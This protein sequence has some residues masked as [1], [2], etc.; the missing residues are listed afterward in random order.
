MEESIREAE[1]KI[2]RRRTHSGDQITG[3]QN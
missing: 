3:N 2:R 1:K